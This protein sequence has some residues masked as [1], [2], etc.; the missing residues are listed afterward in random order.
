MIMI[1]KLI[2]LLIELKEANLEVRIQI[3]TSK[4]VKPTVDKVV[5]P[6][7]N[8][9]HTLFENV[10]LFINDVQISASSSD[11]HY[12]A[13]ISNALTFN[14]NCKTSHMITQGWVND[15]A[16]FFDDCLGGNNGGFKSRSENFR[17]GN[18]QEN[19]YRD[20]GAEFYGRIFHELVACETDMF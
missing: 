13:Y 17:E 6:R 15:E 20:D 5:G 14:L 4:G 7:N 12:K 3:L 19:E 2:R 8:V 1:L 18:I 16:K 10:R 9:L 11:Y